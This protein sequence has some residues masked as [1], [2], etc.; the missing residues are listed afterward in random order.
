MEPS[1][2][3]VAIPTPIHATFTYLHDAELLAGTR[4]LVPF[5]R[6]EVVG[7]VVSPPATQAKPSEETKKITMRRVASV[8]DGTPA[9]SPALLELARWLSGYY[10]HPIGEVL[11]SMLPAST[12]KAIREEI[13]LT[14]AGIA[15]RAA[16]NSGESAISALLTTLFG[17]RLKS[18]SLPTVKKKLKGRNGSSGTADTGSSPDT[19]DVD[20]VLRPLVKQGLISRTRHSGAR[21]RR[22][23]DGDTDTVS[24]A[25][26]GTGDSFANLTEDQSRAFEAIA[27]DLQ[28]A[29]IAD[30]RER[31]AP[32]L[33]RGVTGSGK[34]EVYLHLIRRVQETRATEN[35]PTPQTIVLVPEISLTPQ[36]TR[37]FAARFHGRVAVVHS[38]MTDTDRWAELER[39][40]SG[41]A[42]VLIGPRSAVFAPCANLRLLIVD[43]EHDS[44]YKQATGLTY[45]GRDVA[46][47]RG[48]IEKAL[49]VLGSATP[50]LESWNNAITGRYRL[51]ELPNR[52]TG[53]PLPEVQMVPSENAFKRGTI[54]A[55]NAVAVRGADGAGTENSE[56]RDSPIDRVVLEALRAN[57]RAA[58]Q[59]IVLVN[60]RGYAYYLFSLER[61]ASVQC[62][63]CSI[64]LTLHAR[65]S[66]LRC[67]YCDYSTNLPRVIAAHPEE[68]LVAIGYGS[69]KAESAI[70]AEVP[71]ARVARLDSDTV[72]NRDVLPRVL[73]EFRRGDIDILVGTQM[74]AKGHDFPNV[75]L[76]AILEVDQLLDLPDFR[77]GERT[78]QL[79][80][81]AAGRA[82]RAEKVGRVIIQ[83]ARVG[84]PII[85]L[86]LAQDFHSFAAR[87]LD[88]RRAHGYPPFTRMVAIEFN[89]TDVGLA[90]TVSG[91]LEK[92]LEEA[93]ASRPD[94]F[95]RVRT[96]GPSIPAIEYVRGRHRRQVL[97]V[98]P[99][100]R[101]VRG[102]AQL[103]IGRFA[104][105]PGDM[106]LKVDVDPQSLI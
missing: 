98:G 105:L 31:R 11:R 101:E 36:M 27:L 48:G 102:V 9:Y 106:R 13:H 99:D 6:R 29:S 49:V 15:A 44:S 59:A 80:V 19:V 12:S 53:R 20:E 93:A 67:H 17:A 86:A 69:E 46:V 73:G 65:S 39:M 10:L 28:D 7:V 56:L 50:S 95:A 79:V 32:W 51:A 35:E 62:P 40:R 3:E 37:V 103:V 71:G 4:V 77:S 104:K 88:F 64:S 94:L 78:F 83:T 23:K 60:R 75:T 41:E 5:G 90:R 84:H 26:T 72:V 92:W 43:E 42:S 70:A 66:V 89:T 97:I 55:R 63:H 54:V 33:L 45:N 18:I 52:V 2:I 82:G 8:I 61:R 30:T 47:V 68:T 58:E 21:G 34:T 91:E 14:E 1:K 85:Q 24:A 16:E 76:I 96:L 81:Q 100:P 74:L 22:Q 87:E 25:A 38:A 57:K